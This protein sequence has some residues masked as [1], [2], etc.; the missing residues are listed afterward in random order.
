MKDFGIKRGTH[1]HNAAWWPHIVD[2]KLEK[3]FIALSF[4][5][6]GDFCIVEVQNP[7]SAFPGFGEKPREEFTLGSAS[8]L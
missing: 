6:P 5:N 3:L 7:S 8:R 2:G 4:W 1:I